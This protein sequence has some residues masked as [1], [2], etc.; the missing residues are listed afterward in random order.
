MS[1]FKQV[2]DFTGKGITIGDLRE[3]LKQIPDD[4][5]HNAG[6]IWCESGANLSAPCNAIVPLNSDA[7]IFEHL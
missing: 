6:W 1:L 3:V 5:Q 7:I 2:E 4:A